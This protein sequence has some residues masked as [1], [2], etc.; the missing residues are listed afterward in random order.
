MKRNRM[1]NRLSWRKLALMSMSAFSVYCLSPQN[2][3]ARP[4][5]VVE[6]RIECI[7]N[8]GDGSYTAHFGYENRTTANI[9]IPA[10]E[11]NKFTTGD[12]SRGQPIDFKSGRQYG[13]FKVNFDG[14]PL[15]WELGS[16]PETPTAADS[17][18]TEIEPSVE[19][20]SVTVSGEMVEQYPCRVVPIA[21]CVVRQYSYVN[22]SGYSNYKLRAYFGYYNPFDEP[23]EIPVEEGNNW[24][25]SN[26]GYGSISENEG[27]P[28]V[29]QPGR[30]SGAFSVMIDMPYNWYSYYGVNWNLSGPSGSGETVSGNWDATRECKVF[31]KSGCIKDGCAIEGE[32][33]DRTATFG[34][35]NKE[36]FA[37]KHSKF[38][39]YNDLYPRNGC[40]WNNNLGTGFDRD[41][42][43]CNYPQPEVFEP[44]EHQN[45]F[46]ACF[47]SESNYQ[48]EGGL[49]SLR[50]RLGHGWNDDWYNHNVSLGVASKYCNRPPVCDAG[51]SYK[52]GCSGEVTH[53]FL[54][55][56]LSQDPDRTALKYSWNSS[57]ANAV[58]T[59]EKTL[60]PILTVLV[61]NSSAAQS[62]SVN[63]NIS[64]NEGSDKFTSSCTAGVEI[65]DCDLDSLL[66]AKGVNCSSAD[67]G[68]VIAALIR[69]S[70]QQRRFGEHWVK[71]A[72]DKLG[73]DNV[74]TRKFISALDRLSEE[75]IAAIFSLPSVALSS[76]TGNTDCKA[77]NHSA[78][79]GIL[80]RNSKRSA[81]LTR[82]VARKLARAG[83]QTET[84]RIINSLKTM[85]AKRA[86]LLDQVPES[87]LQ[88]A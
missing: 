84:R 55:G 82:G 5:N 70:K 1:Q 62:C 77:N 49:V 24:I 13:A 26:Y 79:K 7:Q 23:V 58:L 52:V 81:T 30:V 85:S 75:N 83:F 4:S 88:C 21:E 35:E 12:E 38:D 71:T 48:D 44:G 3:F 80:E 67:L 32:R 59:G 40:E 73:A 18:S 86:K 31:P 42:N 22:N 50:W 61:S 65:E 43:V 46:S 16:S 20:S 63:L 78:V 33:G 54:N 9:N 2:V 47:D 56:H 19:I 11:Y 37:V 74:Y 34:Y 60:N 6:P 72:Q 15:T 66:S 29:F 17:M 69:D 68:S 8:N 28:S 51:S 27:Q 10:G 14:N 25:Y 57:C 41:G 36:E 64:E 45:V 39:S 87:S 53:L 76:C